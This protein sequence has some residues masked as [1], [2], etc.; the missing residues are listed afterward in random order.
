MENKK[1]LK[2]GDKCPHCMDNPNITDIGTLEIIPANEP[3]SDEHLM[4]NRCDSTY[5]KFHPV[6]K[7]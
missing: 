1:Y 5:V 6:V 2:E 3:Y 4:C 7:Y